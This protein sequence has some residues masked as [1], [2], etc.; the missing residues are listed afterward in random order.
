LLL[1]GCRSSRTIDA[2]PHRGSG[3]RLVPEA[4]KVTL[5]IPAEAPAGFDES[6]QRAARENC[7]QLKFKSHG[8][9]E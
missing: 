5:E 3:T 1:A 4:V 8:F 6:T 2:A 7:N 9:D